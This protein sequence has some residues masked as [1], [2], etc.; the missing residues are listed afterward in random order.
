MEHGDDFLFDW[1]SWDS[2]EQLIPL[3]PDVAPPDI[4]DLPREPPAVTEPPPIRR[5]TQV[6]KVPNRLGIFKKN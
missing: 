4:P 5:S 6:S 2:D 1:Y 3:A